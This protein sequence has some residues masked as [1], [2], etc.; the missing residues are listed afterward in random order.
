MVMTLTNKIRGKKNVQ[1][2]YESVGTLQSTAVVVS[3]ICRHSISCL[4]WSLMHPTLTLVLC[5]FNC[6]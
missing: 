2:T 6:K 1:V 5:G 3:V 4:V